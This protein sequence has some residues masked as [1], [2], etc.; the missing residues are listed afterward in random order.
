MVVPEANES[1]EK[2]E[3]P[4]ERAREVK[5]QAKEKKESGVDSG[6]LVKPGPKMNKSLQKD[7][8]KQINIKIKNLKENVK[9]CIKRKY[10]D[11]KKMGA[12]F[13]RIKVSLRARDTSLG[14][15]TD[16]EITNEDL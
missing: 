8:K 14:T 16:S 3:Y 4:C 15:R 5:L 13:D 11:A 9:G 6:K 10:S 7:T 2:D 1:Q 12:A